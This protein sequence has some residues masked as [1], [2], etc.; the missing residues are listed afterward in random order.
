ML[1]RRKQKGENMSAIA[2]VKDGQVL[3]SVSSLDKNA[4][5]IQC[6]NGSIFNTCSR[7]IE[8]L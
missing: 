6:R 4:K 1:S 5:A 7:T 8:H 3:E 2:Q